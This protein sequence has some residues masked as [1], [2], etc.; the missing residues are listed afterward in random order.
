MNADNLLEN[1]E[2]LADA[3]GGID[4]LRELLL[5]LGVSGKLLPQIS[6]E[7]REEILWSV[8]SLRL[9]EHRIWGANSIYR[10][11]YF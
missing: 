1:F 6:A 5:H 7:V 11:A 8:D 3:P 10:R 2:I 4:R 9:D